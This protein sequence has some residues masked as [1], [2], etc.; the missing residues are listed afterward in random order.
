MDF[1]LNNKGEVKDKKS[2]YKE[3]ENIFHIIKNGWDILSSEFDIIVNNV[4]SFNDSLDE[5]KNKN[6]KTIISSLEKF[7]DN[8]KNVIFNISLTIGNTYYNSPSKI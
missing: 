1:I 3:K 7:K 4:K 6:F 8:F 5:N 2:N